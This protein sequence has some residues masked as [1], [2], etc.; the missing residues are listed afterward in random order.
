M[1]AQI[2]EVIIEVIN[3]SRKNF[4]GSELVL[5]YDE[6]LKKFDDLVKKGLVKKRGNNLI[7]ISDEAYAKPPVFNSPSTTM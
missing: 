3:E 1:D 2:E 7:S 6:A 4:E 5:K